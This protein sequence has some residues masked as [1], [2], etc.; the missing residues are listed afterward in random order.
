VT[1]GARRPP[2]P[3][4]RKE[5]TAAAMLVAET[6]ARHGLSEAI[7]EQRVAA[8]WDTLVGERIAR[9]AQP[10][11]VHR[12]VLQI[13]VASSAWMHELGLLKPQLLS[14][15]W[16]GL[17]E[18]RLF[19]DLALHLAGKTRRPGEEPGVAPAQRPPPPRPRPP[20]AALGADRA[21]I[22]DETAAIEDDELRELIVRVRTRHGR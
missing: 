21:R 16:R 8:E 18:P 6:L 9:R 4:R 11:G 10:D 7:R 5:A 22:L 17:G 14:A 19:D 20:A 13:R 2:A 15:L 12:R 1:R 3:T